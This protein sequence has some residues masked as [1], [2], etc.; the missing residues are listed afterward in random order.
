MPAACAASARSRAATGETT[1]SRPRGWAGGSGASSGMRRAH[2]L[3]SMDVDSMADKRPTVR[4]STA[5]QSLVDPLDAALD[6]E[7]ARDAWRAT[8]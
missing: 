1:Q 5:S 8:S 3:S 6:A 2:R 7:V 4:L